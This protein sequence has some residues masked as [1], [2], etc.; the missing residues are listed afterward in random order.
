MPL[1]KIM[2]KPGVDRENTRYT[3]EGGWY[4]CDKIRFRAGTPEKIGGWERTSNNTYQGTCRTIFPWVTLASINYNGIGTNLKFYVESGGGYYDITP[5]RTT[6]A[7]GAITFAATNGS[8][9]ITVTNVAHGAATGDF[10]TFSGAVT[11]GGMITATVLN[12]EYQ[13]TEVINANTYTITAAVNANASDTG[14]GGAAVVGA[15]QIPVGAANQVALV[16]W[17]AGPWSSGTWGL[18]GGA[19]SYDN[20]RL[21][22]ADNFGENLV[23]GPSGGGLY[24]WY[25]AGAL[26]N[27]G[28]LISSLPGASDVPQYQRRLLISDVSRFVICIWHQ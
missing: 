3:T 20:I 13:I 15:Y 10:V 26:E 7:A 22:N 19:P 6:T 21:W 18:S 28:V 24:Y 11:L 8:P 16:G 27:R 14:N 5:I 17:G 25:G 9:I 4:E 1:Q 12:K 2:F 23:F